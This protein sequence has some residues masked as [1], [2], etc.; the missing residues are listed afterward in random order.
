M[1]LDIIELKRFVE[2]YPWLSDKNSLVLRFEDLVTDKKSRVN[3]LKRII[4]YIM[5]NIDEE[6]I[7]EYIELM[8]KGANPDHSKTFRKGKTRQWPQYFSSEHNN[9]FKSKAGKLLVDLGYEN[10]EDW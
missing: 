3:S 10:N 6:L 5:P 2:F 4:Q 9:I 7:P 1:C 8:E